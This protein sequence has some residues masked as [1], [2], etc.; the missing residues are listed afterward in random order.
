MF[1]KKLKIEKDVE[2]IEETFSY[3]Y[4]ILDMIDAIQQIRVF[5]FLSDLPEEFTENFPID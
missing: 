3:K 4:E 1:P 2:S 5:Y